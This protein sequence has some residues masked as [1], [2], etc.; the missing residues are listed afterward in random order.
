MTDRCNRRC[1]LDG[2]LIYAILDSNRCAK[3]ISFPTL[4][5][6]YLRL[7]VDYALQAR[8]RFRRPINHMSRHRQAK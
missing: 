6:S 2:D 5:R 7:C 8:T 4:C 3:V 1:K